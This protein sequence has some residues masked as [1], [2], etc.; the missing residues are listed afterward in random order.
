LIYRERKAMGAALVPQIIDAIGGQYEKTVFSFIP[1][2]AET[3]YYGL[4]DGL[5]LHRRKQVREEILKAASEGTLSP[6][7]VDE[8]ILRNWPRGEKIAHKDI[9]LRTFISQEKGRDTLVSHVYDITYGIVNPGDYLVALDDSVVRGT[10]LKKSILK[11]LARTRPAKIVVCSTAPQIRYP[12]CYGIDMSELGKFI[13]FQAAVALHRRAG[14]QSLLDRVYRDCL[15]E[16]KK[17]VAQ[18]VNHVKTVYEAFSDT[19]ISDEISRMV[20][21]EDIDWS[22]EIQVIFQTIKNLHDSIQGDCGDWYF[23]GDYPTPG[24]Y[25]MVNRAYVRWYEGLGG[26]SYD[27]PL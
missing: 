15:E 4:M 9:K 10:T 20:Y 21:P 14:R 3:A 2:T 11:I 16:L 5:R 22:G 6:D 25:G 1:N 19:Q 8:L 13:A 23:T 17:P 7:V 26:R 18:Q 12:D 24:G 27:L